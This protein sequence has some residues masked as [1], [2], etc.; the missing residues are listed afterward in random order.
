MLVEVVSSMAPVSLDYTPSLLESLFRDRPP[1][2]AQDGTHFGVP[3][4]AHLAGN[5][6]GA[7]SLSR[8]NII[9]HL[10]YIT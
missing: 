1:K 7:R 8:E 6:C 10:D 3:S 2:V 5:R 9:A 4:L